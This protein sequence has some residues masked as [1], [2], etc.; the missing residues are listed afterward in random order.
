[1]RLSQFV[2]L[3]FALAFVVGAVVQ[4]NSAHALTGPNS[5]GSQIPEISNPKGMIADYTPTSVG[6]VLTDMGLSWKVEN[7]EGNSVVFA[8]VYG[9]AVLFLMSNC[10]DPSD[11]QGCTD[12]RMLS[13]F[14]GR[15]FSPI[16][17]MRFNVNNVFAFAGS[18]G[19]QEIFFRRFDF[20][21]HGVTRENLRT[22]I[23]SFRLFAE[24]FFGSFRTSVLDAP[25]TKG[26]SVRP[27]DNKDNVVLEEN[28][29]V[30]EKDAEAF[31]EN[32][33]ANDDLVN[34]LTDAN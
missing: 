30:T 3:L 31:I 19:D 34:V 11:P 2:G 4:P 14:T 25:S 26:L 10:D 24:Q 13:V 7:V 9:M 16:N 29:I 18:G 1:M 6:R 17:L 23:L 12:L 21:I 5:G 33:F 20:E 15:S 8:N 22:S 28:G 27:A 32:V